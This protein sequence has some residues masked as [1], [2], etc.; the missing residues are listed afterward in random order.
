M[1]LSSPFTLSIYVLKSRAEALKS[2]DQ[3]ITQRKAD[4]PTQVYTV[5]DNG[6]PNHACLLDGSPRSF[7]HQSEVPGP[8][9]RIQG[10]V[11]ILAPFFISWLCWH[12]CSKEGLLHLLDI[13]HTSWLGRQSENL[14]FSLSSVDHLEPIIYFLCV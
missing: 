9:F 6:I 4:F 5:P 1:L 10:V 12:C 8:S 7:F 2:L 3:S 14:D 13:R 11:D